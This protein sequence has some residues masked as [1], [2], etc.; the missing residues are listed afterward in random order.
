MTSLVIGLTVVAF[1]TSTPELAATVTA[2]LEGAPAVGFGNVVGSNIANLALVLGLAA[3]LRPLAPGGRFLRREMPFMVGGSAVAAW[4]SWDGLV[5]RW[6]GGLLLALLGIFL[7]YLL[8]RREEAAAEVLPEVDPDEPI[9]GMARGIALVVVGVGMLVLGAKAL[10]VGAVTLARALGVAER[11][12][13]LTVVALGT[14]LPELAA[15]VVA[16]QRREG[17][18]VLGNLVGSNLFNL[19]FVLAVAAL[20]TPIEVTAAGARVDLAVMVAVALLSWPLLSLRSGMG[21][22]QGALLVLT[23]VG[24]VAWLFL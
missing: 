5:E 1:A 4:L 23:Y 13:G 7:A 18:I 22:G 6:E 20:V 16:V 21:R 11:V 3:L 19:L 17:D 24:Y 8:L 9:P 2:S 12:I 15:T 10:I 14:S